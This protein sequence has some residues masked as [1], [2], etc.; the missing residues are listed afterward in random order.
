MNSLSA[1]H[2]CGPDHCGK[3]KVGTTLSTCFTVLIYKNC[4]LSHVNIV[5]MT[6]LI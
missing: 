5:S 1:Q 4:C 3:H 6:Y 2:R